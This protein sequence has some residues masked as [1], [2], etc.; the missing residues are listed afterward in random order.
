MLWQKAKEHE[1]EGLKALW[2]Y[3]KS[4]QTSLRRVQCIRKNK[5]SQ[6]SKFL[7]DLFKMA[8]SFLKEKKKKKKSSTLVM[9]KEELENPL[10]K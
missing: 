7:N 5:E 4:C 9:I 2:N 8:S 10:R 6:H 3:V 1:R